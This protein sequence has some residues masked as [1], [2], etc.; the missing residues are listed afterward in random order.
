MVETVRRANAYDSA[1]A[2][3]LVAQKDAQ[4]AALLSTLSSS[5][6]Q[7]TTAA[8]AAALGAAAAAGDL[9]QPG[10][11]SSPA[12]G[13]AWVGL[14]RKRLDEASMRLAKLREMY[15]KEVGG[16]VPLSGGALAVANSGPGGTGSIGGR[17][18]GQGE[19]EA[20]KGQGSKAGA[21]QS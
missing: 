11:L 19:G 8:T 16:H 3:Q 7:P 15:D 6:Y 10:G 2:A 21:G 9:G 5:S 17:R 20:A 13:D 1:E 18:E 4:R 14:A 12:A